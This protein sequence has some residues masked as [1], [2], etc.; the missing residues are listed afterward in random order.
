MQEQSA[1]AIHTAAS[2]SIECKSQNFE[3]FC[4]LRQLLGIAYNV[5]KHKLRV[6]T[7][8]AK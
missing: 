8:L 3:P 5:H 6:V 7:M 4:A 2:R 1:T